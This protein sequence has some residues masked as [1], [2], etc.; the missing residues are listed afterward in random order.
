[1]NQLA[2]LLELVYP[3]IHHITTGSLTYLSI[4]SIIR[5]LLT[6][7]SPSTNLPLERIKTTSS[8]SNFS[9][10]KNSS[11]SPF[12]LILTPFN[13][14]KFLWKQKQKNDDIYIHIHIYKSMLFSPYILYT[15]FTPTIWLKPN[16]FH[17]RDLPHN[18]KIFS[19]SL[20]SFSLHFILVNSY[21]NKNKETIKYSQLFTSDY[22]INEI[23]G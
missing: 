14:R 3:I 22:P 21:K 11:F 23:K 6:D 16:I 10:N 4:D 17:S 13:S 2:I 15:L 12:I 1:M 20:F 7:S 19:L 9:K 8:L 5:L 18:K